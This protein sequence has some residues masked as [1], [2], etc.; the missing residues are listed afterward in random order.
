LQTGTGWGPCVRCWGSCGWFRFPTDCGPNEV[1]QPSSAFDSCR[2]DCDRRGPRE[3]WFS[4]AGTPRTTCAPKARFCVRFLAV[5][6][7]HQQ[8]IQ[9]SRL[10]R[11]IAA[12][13]PLA[14]RHVLCRGPRR[15]ER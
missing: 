11:D 7:K 9:S 4:V 13:W 1:R 2:S 10:E 6:N 5:L 3:A 12:E 14:A 15:F 8:S